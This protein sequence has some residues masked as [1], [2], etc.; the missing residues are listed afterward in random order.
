MH[1]NKNLM[2]SLIDAEIKRLQNGEA[3]GDLGTRLWRVR[4]LEEERKGLVAP[5]EAPLVLLNKTGG[6]WLGA[7]R[8]WMKQKAIN[9]SDVTW[10][11]NEHLRFSSPPTVWDMEYLAACIASATLRDVG[12][13]VERLPGD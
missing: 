3:E 5:A 2:V 1:I 7:V 6:Q 9:G 13:Y 12:V 11:S 8:E 10:G 4:R